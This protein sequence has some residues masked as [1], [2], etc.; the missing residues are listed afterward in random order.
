MISINVG[1]STVEASWCYLAWAIG[2]GLVIRLILCVFRELELRWPNTRVRSERIARSERITLPPN[3][4]S[5]VWQA[6]LSTHQSIR[7]YWLSFSVGLL[8]LLAYPYFIAAGNLKVIGG[9][10]AL[11]T[12]VRWSQ[13][14]GANRAPYQR[15][16]LGNALVIGL[17]VLLAQ[18]LHIHPG[19]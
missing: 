7:D 9:W 5:S 19:S 18:M 17:S 16:L 1:H 3:C 10:L 8:E 11:K 4:F 12:A 15:F 2:F 6:F 13:W 14:Q